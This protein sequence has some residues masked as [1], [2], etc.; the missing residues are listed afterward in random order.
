VLLAA[1]LVAAPAVALATAGLPARTE[2]AARRGAEIVQNMGCRGC[3]HIGGSGGDL[4]P[5]L[6]DV[7]QRRGEAFVREKIRNPKKSNAATIMPQ[8]PL[9]GDDIDAVVAYLEQQGKQREAK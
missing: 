7:I 1:C 4:G 6:D 2:P 3:H 8:M 9:S 5:A